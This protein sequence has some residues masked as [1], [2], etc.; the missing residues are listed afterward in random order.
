M[1]QKNISLAQKNTL[2]IHC[3][4][5]FFS[6]IHNKEELEEAFEFAKKENIQTRIL[7][8][9]SNILLPTGILSGLTIILKNQ[10]FNTED[11][12]VS[13][14]AGNLLGPTII[15]LAQKNIDLSS[16]TG[17]PSSIGGAVRGNAGLLGKSIG[18]YLIS[19][20]LFDT[21]SKEFTTWTQKDFQ[22]SYRNSELKK[23]KHLIFWEGKFAFPKGDSVLQN[24]QSLMKERAS[25]QPQGKSAGSFFKNPPQSDINT[26]GYS[27][28]YFI[29]QCGLKGTQKGEAIISEKHANFFLNIGEASQED[30]LHLIHLAQEK[31]KEKFGIKLELE[32][33]VVKK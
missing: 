3:I 30:F 2:G 21:K 31:V 10:V 1:I 8:L 5:E 13:L 18:D 7:G 20:K 16:L 11:E 19:A 6:E 12:T 22:F 26:E 33:E 29:D 9:G 14:G 24:V 17:F 4:A 15:Q 27:A 32:V 25:K 28:G 23:Q